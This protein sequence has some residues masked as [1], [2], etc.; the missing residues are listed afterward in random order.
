M[1]NNPGSRLAIR[2]RLVALAGCLCAVG[3][4]LA[5]D[6]PGKGLRF[7]SPRVLDLAESAQKVDGPVVPVAALDVTE[8]QKILTAPALTEDQPSLPFSDDLYGC[9]TPSTTC[10]QQHE[11]KLIDA[12]G[13][14]VKR[15]GKRLTI[16]PKNGAPLVFIDWTDPHS[17][18][19]DGDS[20]THWYLGRLSGSGY[21]RVEVQFGQDAPGSFL[22][23][24]ASGKTAFVHNGSDIAVPSPD[25]MHLVT[26]NR[27]N[28][29][30]SIR[31]AALDATGP[32][33]QLQC[34]VGK[35]S[36]HVGGDFKGWHDAHG[37]DFTLKTR[38]EH[39]R[40][41]HQIA[42]R[43]TLG[44]SGWSLATADKAQLAAIGLACK[45]VQ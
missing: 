18:N 14:S 23:N 33:L 1:Q 32:R 39:S 29:P 12:A 17:R 13:G 27:D 30:L 34:D 19:A 5:K 44:D 31:V 35:D 25:G 11:R 21:L 43:V 3:A 8:A 24:P 4:L 41:E 2:P 26:F 37:F 7:S 45:E 16:A 9:K 36:E 38:A 10:S 28:P 40:L 15:D 42:L 6:D 22:I 20:Q